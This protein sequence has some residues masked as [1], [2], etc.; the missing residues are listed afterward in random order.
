MG[1]ARTRDYDAGRG[2]IYKPGTAP[3][4]AVA[5][6]LLDREHAAIRHKGDM[7]EDYE[8]SRRLIL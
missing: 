7:D 1:T 4:I 6:G 5:P 3:Y 2:T 8:T